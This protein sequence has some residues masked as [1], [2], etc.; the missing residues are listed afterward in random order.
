M[1]IVCVQPQD[2][3]LWHTLVTRAGSSVFHSPE[4]LRVL[5]QT[6][7]FDIKA[8]VLVDPEGEP[9]AGIP[10]CEVSDVWRNRVLSLPFSDY[11]DPL[12]PQ[13]DHWQDLIS[14]F[15]AA[16]YYLNLRCL[17]NQMP[18]TDEQFEVVKQA[19]WHGLDLQPDLS[20]L[21]DG[22]ESS[23]Q[24]AVKKA[25]KS[26]VVIRRAEQKSDLRAFFEMH[27]SLRKNKYRLLA[28]PYSFFEAIWHQFIEAQKGT[29]LV[30]DHEGEVIAGIL[31]LEWQNTLY[32]KFNAS[33]ANHLN[34]RPTDLLIWE[35]VQY[36]KAKGYTYLDFGLS[37][38]DQEGLLRFKRKF[39]T[40]EKTIS[41]LQSCHLSREKRSTA[42]PVDEAGHKLLPQL[43]D[44]FTTEHVPDSVTEKAGELLYRFFA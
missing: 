32:Y 38:W 31:F 24:R 17:H 1:T 21:W 3:P 37:D 43:T 41:F 13:A 40:E 23:A 8:Y 14:Y 10:F 5:A 39:A 29:L 44:L 22:F 20:D 6:Y 27:L 28:Q 36:G 25:Q 11:C 26:G 16:G 7:Q 30:A 18:L 42:A 9:Q 34:V 4:W 35:G 15:N 12:V 33:K 2:D 19:K